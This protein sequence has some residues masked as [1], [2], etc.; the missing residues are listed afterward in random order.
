VDLSITGLRPV[1]A[2]AAPV[3]VR[4]ALT[5]APAMLITPHALQR[6]DLQRR[7]LRGSGGS[8]GCAAPREQNG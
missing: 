6:R 5:R 7:D 3:F 4:A 1:F 2:F 8:T